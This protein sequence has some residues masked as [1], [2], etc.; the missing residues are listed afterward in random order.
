MDPAGLEIL[1][2]MAL[3]VIVGALLDFLFLPHD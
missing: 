1:G 3:M 2:I